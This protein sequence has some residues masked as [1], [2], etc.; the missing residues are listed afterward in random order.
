M[1]SGM[2]TEL[3][4]KRLKLLLAVFFTFSRRSAI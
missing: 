1:S 2:A 3:N 4:Q